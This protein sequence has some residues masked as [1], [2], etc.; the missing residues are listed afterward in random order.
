[1]PAERRSLHVGRP[2]PVHR[3]IGKDADKNEKGEVSNATLT[4][5]IT[6]SAGAPFNTLGII[7]ADHSI[8]WSNGTKW[9]KQ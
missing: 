9:Q 7:R 8:D 6:I 5:D 1:M 2:N 3:A 4:S